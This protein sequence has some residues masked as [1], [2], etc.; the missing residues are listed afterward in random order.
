VASKA[1]FI[2][3][4]SVDPRVFCPRSH[5]RSLTADSRKKDENSKHGDDYRYKDQVFSS[6]T[7]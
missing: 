3:D 2:W 1:S 7:S 6:H 5:R 4:L